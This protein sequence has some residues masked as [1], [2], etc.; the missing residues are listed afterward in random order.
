MTTQSNQ[1]QSDHQSGEPLGDYI[2]RKGGTRITSYIIPKEGPTKAAKRKANQRAKE[3]ANGDSQFYI[4]MTEDKDAR[5][6]V[7]AVA[8]AVKDNPKVRS[9]ISAIAAGDRF[10]QRVFDSVTDDGLE[11]GD[12]DK[13][14]T[15]DFRDGLR[16]VIDELLRDKNQLE[17][18]RRIL[19][20]PGLAALLSELAEAQDLNVLAAAV[21]R[22]QLTKTILALSKADDSTL[23]SV[24]IIMRSPAFAETVRNAEVDPLIRP[25]VTGAILNPIAVTKLISI[26]DV[27]GIWAQIL[28]LILRM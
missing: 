1:Y 27:G 21:S 3:K 4:V 26:L 23:L 2:L 14:V 24:D 13:K 16:S 6:T 7:R 20:Q 11:A 18:I 9:T 25:A 10:L 12:G 17:P 28:R 19:S 8:A 22:P 15:R 5:E